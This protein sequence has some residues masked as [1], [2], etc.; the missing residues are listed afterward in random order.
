MTME[1]NSNFT[2][3]PL[4]DSYGLKHEPASVKN[5]QANAI[6][7]QVDQAIMMMLRTADLELV[8]M[9]NESDIADFLTSVTWAVCST[10]HTVLKTSPVASIFGQEML[11]DV[12]FIADWSK[13][14]EQRQKQTDKNTGQENDTNVDWDY[15]LRDKVLLDKDGIFRKTESGY[16]SDPRPSRQFIQ[17]TPSGL[18]WNKI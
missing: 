9:V 10:Y 15:Q 16:E 12:P 13:I 4:C 5:P 11:F 7:K 14:G 1:V 3:R 18:T 8:D 6:L 2:S 17:M